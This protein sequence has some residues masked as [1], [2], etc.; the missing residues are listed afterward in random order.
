MKRISLL[1]LT[2]LFFS[3]IVASA[4]NENSS[5]QVERKTKASFIENKGQFKLRNSSFKNA[6]IKYVYDGNQEDFYFTP[7]GLSI[8]LTYAKK[9][10]K[11]PEEKKIRNA[12]KKIGF[13]DAEEFR[14]FEEVGHRQHIEEDELDLIWLGANPNV[15]IV[16]EDKDEHYHSYLYKTLDGNFVNANHA[17]SWKKLTYKNLYPNIDVVYEI[18]PEAGFKYSIVVRPGGDLSQVQLKYSKEAN[19]LNNGTIE[20]KTDFGAMIDHKPLTFY[21]KGGSTTAQG[22]IIESNYKLSANIISFELANYNKN[23]TI[24]IDPWTQTPNFPSS[25]WDCVWECER[26]GAGNVYIIGGTSPLQL[27]K[28]DALG[29][30]QWTF[31]TPYD[32]TEWLGTFATDLAGNSYVS[33]GSPAKIF[34]IDNAATVVW[35]NTNPGG[36]LSLTEFWNITFNCDQTKLVI[37]GTDGAPFSGPQP[38]IFDIDLGTGNVLTSVKVHGGDLLNAQEVRSIT[39]CNN[40]KYY[41]LT[42]DSIG[43]IH[44]SLTPC[45]PT[46]SNAIFR[47]DN[48][49]DL[50]YKCE[51]WRYNNAGIMALAHYNGFIFVHRGNELQKRDFNTANIV[52]SV[53]IPN[54]IFNTSF[55]GNSVGCSGIDIDDCGNIYVGSVNG[56]YKFDQ[57]LSQLAVYPTSYNVYDIEVNS[58]GEFIACGSTG[59]SSSGNRTGFIQ[60]FFASACVPQAIVCCDATICPLNNLCITDS[61]QAVQ[62]TT[63]GGT[64]SASCGSCIDSV[65]GVF[66]PALAGAGTH[67][68]IYS[69]ACGS[70]STTVVVGLCSNLYICMQTDSSLT[71]SNG[72]G[73]YTWSEW[74]PGGN[75]P[76]TNQTECTACGY[77]WF[78]N[79]CLNGVIPVTTCNT[80]AGWVQIATGVNNIPNPSAWPIQVVD[81][82]SS[83]LTISGPGIVPLCAA[84]P[85]ITINITNQIDA[86]CFGDSTGSITF[87]TTTGAAP[88]DYYLLNGVNTLDSL[89]NVTG[90]QTFSNLSAGSYSIGLIDTNNCL[91]LVN[92]TINAPSSNPAIV[93][94][95]TIDENC[96]LLD[97]AIYMTASGGTLN[98]TY[99]WSNGASTEDLTG[100][101]AGVYQVTLTDANGCEAI[102]N[103]IAVNN[104]SGLS[105]TVD[106][107]QT[108]ACSGGNN[109]AILLTTNGGTS[110]YSYLWSNNETTEDITVLSAGTY[111]VTISDATGCSITSNSIQLTDPTAI[112]ILVDS[113]AAISCGTSDGF[114]AISVSGG[115]PNYSFLWSNGATTEDLNNL[116]TPG[117]YTITVTDANACTATASTSIGTNSGMTLTS[118]VNDALCNGDASGNIAVLVT[119]GTAPLTY[120]WSTMATSSSVSGLGAGTYSLSV[121]DDNGCLLLWDTIVGEPTALVLT[122]DTSSAVSCVGFADGQ[123]NST[124]TGGTP[125]YSYFWSNGANTQNIAG[126]AIGAYSLTATDANGCTISGNTSISDANPIILTINLITDTLDCDANPIGALTALAT[127]GAGS[128]TYLWSNGATNASISG[129]TAGDYSVT[130]TDTNNCHGSDS[131]TIYTLF[132]PS[133]NPYVEV[134][135]QTNVLITLGDS[136]IVS[137]GN[138]QVSNGVLY[139]WASTSNNG[140]SFGFND[141]NAPTT[142]ALPNAGDVYSLTVT[143]TSADSCVASDTLLVLVQGLFNGMPNAFTPNNDGTND[144]FG[145]VGLSNSDVL[146]FR[147][148]NRWGQ[149]IYNNNDIS[150]GGWDGNYKGVPQPTE[151]YIYTLRYKLLGQE[152][153][154][155]KGECTLI[156]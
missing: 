16:M 110:P 10:T 69:L 103:S 34:K 48:G 155:M 112:A 44:Q 49:I 95:S 107:I 5:W 156:R 50:G 52:A 148:F 30:L 55:A 136:I 26:D 4:Q 53:S 129:L 154:L 41:F 93:L 152:E 83:I 124:L 62:S 82:S 2:L 6:E 102:S 114:I 15:E 65:T 147:I 87:N 132:V 68:I 146:E 38:Y 89:I 145:P 101:G 31:N 143:A 19:L 72:T 118:I 37:A 29:A 153:Q 67:T 134:P 35:N 139:S 149:E 25:N 39:P 108:I 85:P 135:G 63:T 24:V 106:S 115:T 58:G 47:V 43:W 54:G 127:G 97:G 138:N 33:N 23:K 51:D 75:T 99:L 7:K 128:F 111:Q 8:E 123:L 17:A 77:T 150:N 27:I 56:V 86:Q 20:T 21:A 151:V 98:Y 79:A 133:V 66:D 117:N 90:T 76:I 116:A 13:K 78:F 125:N 80:P 1:S 73:P 64:F 140:G 113:S 74:F 88:Y 91:G 60:S 59:T 92:F 61:A 18:H 105:L 9:R 144:F 109:G 57:N 12:K 121:T 46:S 119:G 120:L 137:S 142:G 14:A 28:Y 36:L 22:K 84:C 42:H 96:G 104:S 45:T 131:A 94:D 32:T 40:G 70:D 126:L 71:V 100:L 11:S 81:N 122:L 141:P 3:I 130:A